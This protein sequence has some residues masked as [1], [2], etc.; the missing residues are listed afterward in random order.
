MFTIEAGGMDNNSFLTMI[1]MT[2]IL[3][4]SNHA[5]NPFV[6][7]FVSRKFRRALLWL[8]CERR[9]RNAR[10]EEWKDLVNNRQPIRMDSIRQ[11]RQST[12]A[13][14]YDIDNNI[15]D[16]EREEQEA[17]DRQSHFQRNDFLV[18][19]EHLLLE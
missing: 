12:A 14:L 16:K 18:L 17:M 8:C 4:Y 19:Y 9:R 13:R 15:R 2:R 5:I 1:Y 10:L 3:M 7:N 6:Y 11:Q